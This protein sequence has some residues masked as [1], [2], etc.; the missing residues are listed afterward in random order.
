[1]NAHTVRLFIALV[2]DDE[3]REQLAVWRDAWN[4]P[5][6]ATPVKTGRLHMTLHFLGD[7]EPDRMTQLTDMLPESFPPFELALRHAGL[8]PH[9]IAVLEPDSVPAELKDLH[10]AIAVVLQSLGLPL[11]A[12]PYRP[13]VT[14]ARRAAGALLQGA[15]PP[16]NW[17]VD[18]YALM[19]STLGP[20]GGYTSV[21]EFGSATP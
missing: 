2:P 21:R 4:W 15:G 11:D 1:M 6:S 13:H 14:L 19:Q 10:A 7:V 3:V 5:R 9:G 8:W 16:V 17:R 12:R 18:R 20:D